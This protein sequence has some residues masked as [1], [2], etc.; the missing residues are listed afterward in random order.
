MFYGYVKALTGHTFSKEALACFIENVLR[1]ILLHT[2]ET[3]KMKH[4]LNVL[5][6]I[7]TKLFSYTCKHEDQQ[8]PLKYVIRRVIHTDTFYPHLLIFLE[9]V[10]IKSNVT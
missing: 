1:S 10:T 8:L 6:L 5:P 9:E 3:I 7:I 4:S 2:N